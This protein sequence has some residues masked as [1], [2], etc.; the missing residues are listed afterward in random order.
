M[1]QQIKRTKVDDLIDGIKKLQ[2]LNDAGKL[3]N[4]PLLDD[5]LEKK[6]ELEKEGVEEQEKSEFTAQME[7]IANWGKT[8]NE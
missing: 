2:E 8:E 6:A 3:K 7:M 5:L 1:P 4:V